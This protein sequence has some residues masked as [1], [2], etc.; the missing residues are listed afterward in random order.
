V[1]RLL[2]GMSSTVRA[3][4]RDKPTGWKGEEVSGRRGT[5]IFSATAV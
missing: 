2:T 5:I 4:A 3:A 1:Q